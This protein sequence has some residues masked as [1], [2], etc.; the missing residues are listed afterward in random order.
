[1]DDDTLVQY[2]LLRK[3]L[4]WP[5]GAL[6]AQACHATAAV[7]Y[8]FRADAETIAYLE[9]ADSMHKVVLGAESEAALMS[10]ASDLKLAGIGHR[11]WIEMPEGVAT[12]LATK[13]TR[14]GAVKALLASFKL[15]R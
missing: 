12:C 11:L 4:K 1:M 7:N 5:T 10:A 2:V 8:S 13:P 6:I 15:L 9:A 14:R 3:D